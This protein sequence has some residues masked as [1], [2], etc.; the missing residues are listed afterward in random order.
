MICEYCNEECQ[1]TLICNIRSVED[2][3]KKKRKTLDV[4][5]R[6]CENCSRGVQTLID[7][8]RE[9]ENSKKSKS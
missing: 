8:M 1:V 9:I 7:T 3:P 4:D 5:A 6:I 2:T